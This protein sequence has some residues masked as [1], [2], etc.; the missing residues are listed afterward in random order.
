MNNDISILIIFIRVILETIGFL[1]II[2]FSG[3]VLITRNNINHN[4]DLR[5]DQVSKQ[6]IQ[7]VHYERYAIH[8][9]MFNHHVYGTFSL[10]IL[11]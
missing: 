10:M 8:F 1:L 11:E 4:Q 6:V 2:D 9:N 5:Y 7:S 3:F